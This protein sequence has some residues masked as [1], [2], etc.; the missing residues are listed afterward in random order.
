MIGAGPTALGA[1]YRLYELSKEFTNISLI[2]FEQ[3]GKPGGL[4]AS[5]RDDQGFLW[6][7][8]GHVVFSHYEFFDRVLDRAIKDWNVRKRAAYAFMKGSD[9]KRRFIPYPVQ[10]NIEVMDKV[11]QQKSLSGLEEIAANPTKEKP[12]NFDQW[13]LRSFGAGLSEVFMSKYSRKVWTVDPTEMNSVWTG[14]RVAVPDI[15]KIM[16]KIAE[17]DNGASAKDSAWGPN[18]VFRFPRCKGTGGIWQ[19]VA[20]LVPR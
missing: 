12:A 5:E 9:G 19:A 10:N 2:N 3:S 8:G 7:M 11:D 17:Y 13:L 6:D 18:N 4:A 20:D 15:I 16:R 1:A 14:E